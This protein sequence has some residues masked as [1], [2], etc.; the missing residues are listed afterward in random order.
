MSWSIH[1]SWP[2]HCDWAFPQG[3]RRERLGQNRGYYGPIRRETGVF[4]REAFSPGGS[5]C[6][7]KHVLISAYWCLDVSLFFFFFSIYPLSLCFGEST[8]CCRVTTRLHNLLFWDHLYTPDLRTPVNSKDVFFFFSF[9]ICSTH[10][11]GQHRHLRLRSTAVQNAM[12]RDSPGRVCEP[13]SGS[14]M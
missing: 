5:P 13:F 9:S 11:N 4:R 1:G 12:D 8:P 2:T 6:I 7:S 14:W 10:Q 3:Y